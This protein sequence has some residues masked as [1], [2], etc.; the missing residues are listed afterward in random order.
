[1]NWIFPNGYR[2]GQC[3]IDQYLLV[4]KGGRS[5]EFFWTVF[6]DRNEVLSCKNPCRS[7]VEAQ[8]ICEA[9]YQLHSSLNLQTQTTNNIKTS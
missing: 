5:R 4:V 9:I 2:D 8:R 1:M 7:A 6:Y 3:E